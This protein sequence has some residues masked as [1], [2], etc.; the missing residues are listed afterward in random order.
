LLDGGLRGAQIPLLAPANLPTSPNK[1]SSEEALF[2][3]ASLFEVRG[4]IQLLAT[5]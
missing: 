2:E 3:R 4:A 5:S 1:S